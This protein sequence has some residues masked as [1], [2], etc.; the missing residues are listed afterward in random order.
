[1]ANTLNS[2]PLQ[3]ASGENTSHAVWLSE[4]IIKAPKSV[5]EVDDTL[6]A[7]QA[8]RLAID[9]AV[10]V[11]RSDFQNAKNLLQA[12]GRRLDK[13][14]DRRKAKPVEVGLAQQFHLHRQAQAQ[15]ARILNAVL[16]PIQGDYQIEL[17]RA[18]DASI[19]FNEAWGKAAFKARALV[20][21][22]ELMGLIGGHE[23]RKKG[24]EIPA[25]G[26]APNNRIHP[27]YGVYSPVRGEY[28]DL[29]QNTPLP[30]SAQLP[31]SVLVE[32][33]AGTG[34]LSAVLATRASGV[35]VAT[36]LDDRAVAC[37]RFNLQNL[38]LANRVD[39][40]Q[41]DMFPDRQADLVVCNPPWLPAKP[42]APIE[43]A[44]YDENSQM[45]KSYLNGLAAHLNPGGEGWLILSDLAEHLQLRTRAE[46]E[47]WIASAG[48][49]VLGRHDVRPVH[50][51][52]FDTTDPLHTARAQEVTSLWR[53][54]ALKP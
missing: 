19:A 17:R 38:G 40:I 27:F 10:M 36:E 9:G 34:V 51:K 46:L 5:V 18:P 25:L 53:L 21:L 26:Q 7:D 3:W 50:G 13:K 12:L 29:V 31:G 2:I 20:S 47:H 43:R 28:I 24:V 16:I 52:A 23:W 37:A 44:I 30:V 42:S 4:R 22:R 54:Q 11:W 8:Y 35:V 32:V 45:L 33:G 15:R 1:M 49:T 6:T 39:L 14:T 48:L 41:C